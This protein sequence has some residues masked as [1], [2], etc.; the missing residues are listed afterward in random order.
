MD[1]INRKL[2]AGYERLLARGY[3][4]VTVL[5]T[6]GLTSHAEVAS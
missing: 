6:D 4:V 2:L 5:G 1:A 3:E